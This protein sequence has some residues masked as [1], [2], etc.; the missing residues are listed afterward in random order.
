M[1]QRREIDLCFAG[2][3]LTVERVGVI[4]F[5][6]SA[7]D[8]DPTVFW[9]AKSESE[10]L[11]VLAFFS[12]FSTMSWLLVGCT[13]TSLIIGFML[14]AKVRNVDS[15]GNAI[16]QVLVIF[17]QRDLFKVEEG[18]GPTLAWQCLK[19]TSCFSAFLLFSFYSGALTSILTH[20]PAPL[21]LRSYQDIWDQG[22]DLAMVANTATETFVQNVNPDNILHRIYNERTLKKPHL[23]VERMD[24]IKSRMLSDRNI[25]LVGPQ[26]LLRGHPL[27]SMVPVPPLQKNDIVTYT[28]Q[29]DSEFQDLF[30]HVLFKL[31]EMGAIHKLWRHSFERMRN[32]FQDESHDTSDETVQLDY[33]GLFFPFLVMMIGLVGS[34]ILS[35]FEFVLK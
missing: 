30:S 10:F 24:D 20:R 15:V 19:L 14:V 6:T 3:S 16:G 8:N 2:L 27:F 9:M 34:V 17:L 12:I 22:L 13:V 4:D 21:S 7:F 32:A 25:L 29:K 11:D 26:S 18:Q 33:L 23:K 35:V 28:F 1:L 5:A 31:N